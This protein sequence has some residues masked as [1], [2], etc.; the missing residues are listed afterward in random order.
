MSFHAYYI[1]HWII[2]AVHGQGTIFF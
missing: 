2:V 1:T